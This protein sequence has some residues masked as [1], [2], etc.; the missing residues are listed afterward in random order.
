MEA[1][2]SFKQEEGGFQP[3]KNFNVAFQEDLGKRLKVV[4]PI[5]LGTDFE[6]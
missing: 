1:A 3:Q 4:L 6:P 5:L 2:S